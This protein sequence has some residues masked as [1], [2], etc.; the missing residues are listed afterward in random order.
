MLG[1][2]TMEFQEQQY[3]LIEKLIKNMV[4]D[5]I[6]ASGKRKTTEAIEKHANGIADVALT[7][8]YINKGLEK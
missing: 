8:G 5:V 4:N 3:E 6:G 1:E 2:T 7:F